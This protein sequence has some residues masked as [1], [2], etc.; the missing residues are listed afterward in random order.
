[1]KSITT[2]QQAVEAHAVVRTKHQQRQRDAL[3]AFHEVFLQRYLE[4]FR[5]TY[6]AELKAAVEGTGKFEITMRMDIPSTVEPFGL[7]ELLEKGTHL[8][9]ISR[10]FGW[11]NTNP[12]IGVTAVCKRPWFFK[13]CCNEHTPEDFFVRVTMWFEIPTS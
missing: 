5:K 13:E 2:M 1:M 7:K 3:L 9:N 10:A 4:H 12:H 6:Y 11:T 8:I